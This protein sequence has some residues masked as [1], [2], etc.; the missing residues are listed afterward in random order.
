[1][2]LCKSVQ[3]RWVAQ[4]VFCPPPADCTPGSDKSCFPLK[5]ASQPAK[6]TRPRPAPTHTPIFPGF[7][8]KGPTRRVI[9]TNRAAR[10]RRTPYRW[11]P[12]AHGHAKVSCYYL[13][14]V[15][16][17]LAKSADSL[18]MHTVHCCLVRRLSPAINGRIG[19]INPLCCGRGSGSSVAWI[20]YGVSWDMVIRGLVLDRDTLLCAY[21]AISDGLAVYGWHRTGTPRGRLGTGSSRPIFRTCGFLGFTGRRLT[22]W[23]ALAH[24]ASC[25]RASSSAVPTLPYFLDYIDAICRYNYLLLVLILRIQLIRM[26]KGGGHLTFNKLYQ[27]GL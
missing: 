16:Q 9:V 5:Q 3:S 4:R 25:S 1:M 2:I 24:L 17:Q 19:K 14:V 11:L 12:R 26:A 13:Q 22:T 7:D 21:V 15:S 10:R 27:E 6:F 20:H 23:Q 18:A 8:S